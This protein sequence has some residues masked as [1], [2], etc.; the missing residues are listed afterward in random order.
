MKK[1]LIISHAKLDSHPRPFKQI[2]YL[3]DIYEV[4]TIGLTPPPFDNVHFFQFKRMSLFKT[5]LR[6]PLLKLH[7]YEKYYWDNIKKELLKNFSNIRYDLIIA[8]DIRNFPLALRIAKGAKI[9]LDA[10]EYSPKNFDDNFIWKFFIK[11]YYIYLC[12]K[13]IKKCDAMFT[14]SDGIAKEYYHNFGIRSD[15]FTNAAEY[16]ELK[17]SI[18]SSETIKLIHHGSAS[19]SRKIELMIEMMDYLDKRFSLYLMLVKSRTNKHYYYKLKKMA[20]G[21]KNVRIISAVPYSKIADYTNKYDIGIFLLPPTNF[22]LKYALPNKFFEFI[23][24]RLAIAIGPSIE[25]E[26][27]VNKYDLGVIAEDFTPQSMAKVLNNLNINQIRYY[28]NQSNKYAK[29]L[30]YESNKEK[31]KEIISKLVPH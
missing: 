10:H 24:A 4:H 26:K 18:V 7:L 2:K 25:M 19:P 8:H 21:K 22:N 29:L 30:S 1:I 16:V 31:I 9:I 12:K 17:P 14:V 20:E 6:L 27:V 5:I 15:I 28:K 11:K 23:Q 3:K 13:Y